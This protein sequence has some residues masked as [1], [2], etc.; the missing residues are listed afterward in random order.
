MTESEIRSFTEQLVETIN[1]GDWERL[2]SL[3]DDDAVLYQATVKK[4]IVGADHIIN[5]IK[6]F[7]EMSKDWHATIRELYIVGD[8]AIMEVSS[9]GTHTGRFLDYEPTGRRFDINNCL[10]YKI[11]D[12]KII[13]Q[14]TYF[15]A[16]T[17]LRA[18]GLITIPGA[19]PEAA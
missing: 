13:K 11:K 17:L 18:L 8:T 6:D 12:G 7:G 9:T 2:R 16:A 3:Y 5:G 15:D 1:S 4:T 10:I 19:R 14:T